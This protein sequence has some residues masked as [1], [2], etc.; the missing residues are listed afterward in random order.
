MRA[1]HAFFEAVSAFFESSRVAPHIEVVMRSLCILTLLLAAT[2]LSSALADETFS[3]AP[4][5]A[6]TIGGGEGD[7]FGVESLS[8]KDRMAVLLLRPKGED[9]TFRFPLFVGR[10]VQLRSQD[11]SGQ[12]L[13]C[14]ATLRSITDDKRAQFAA[15][16]KA[17]PRSD[18][19]KCPLE[20]DAAAAVS[21]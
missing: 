20:P 12:S 6:V 8:E 17:Q 21:K 7:T 5:Q 4:E 18:E 13:L 10:S 15:D 14:S 3:V 19:R 11:A 9:C 1:N 2:F 16:C